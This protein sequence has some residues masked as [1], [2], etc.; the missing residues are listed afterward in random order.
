MKFLILHI[1][2]WLAYNKKY[3]AEK[4]KTIF[5]RDYIT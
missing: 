2:Y 5:K 3:I 1:K 4:I